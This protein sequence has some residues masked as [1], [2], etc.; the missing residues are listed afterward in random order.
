MSDYDRGLARPSSAIAPDMAIDAGLRSFMLGVYNKVALGL[1]LSAALAWV[2]GN[3]PPARALL[4]RQ[5]E[6][7]RIG[8]T[9]LGMIVAF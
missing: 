4:F 5:D 9:I 8:Y 3:Y 1:V 7:G 2:T 6:Y